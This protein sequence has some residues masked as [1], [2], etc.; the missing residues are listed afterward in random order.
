MRCVFW[1]KLFCYMLAVAGPFE[2][3]G[4]VVLYSIMKVDYLCYVLVKWFPSVLLFCAGK[5]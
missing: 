5:H 4:A 3:V 2:S 1:G